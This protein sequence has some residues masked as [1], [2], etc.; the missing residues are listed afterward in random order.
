M[1][2]RLH[3]RCAHGDDSDKGK[4]TFGLI[5]YIKK[6][7]NLKYSHIRKTVC[8]RVHV[9]TSVMLWIRLQSKLYE[10]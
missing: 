8:A 2:N 7:T 9:Y 5:P 1:C 4:G 10:P 6:D 3:Y